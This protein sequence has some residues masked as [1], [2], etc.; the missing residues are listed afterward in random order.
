MDAG[1]GFEME[2]NRDAP[3]EVSLLTERFLS[4]PPLHESYATHLIGIYTYNEPQK[5]EQ[6]KETEKTICVK[7]EQEFG[8]FSRN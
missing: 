1:S 6:Q 3:R 4:F 5:Q 8:N 7:K 2:P